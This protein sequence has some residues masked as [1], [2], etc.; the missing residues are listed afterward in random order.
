MVP[1]EGA[2]TRLRDFQQRRGH[3]CNHRRSARV[4]ARAELWMENDVHRD[5]PHGLRMVDRLVVDLPDAGIRPGRS[6]RATSCALAY[7]AH[8]VRQRA[9]PVESVPGPGMV[10][11]YFLVP[12]VSEQRP[13]LRSREDWDDGVDSIRDRRPG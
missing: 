5:W 8:A 12:A 13:W 1:R 10:L 11:L 7:D 4:M 2:G 6:D 9:H 3:R